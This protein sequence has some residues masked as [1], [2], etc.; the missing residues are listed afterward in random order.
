MN[1]KDIKNPGFNIKS[2][3]PPPFVPQ[4]LGKIYFNQPVLD[5]L[6]KPLL[7]EKD[8]LNNYEEYKNFE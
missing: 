7:R 2:S 6:N 1:G 4:Y 8:L 5:F 3:L